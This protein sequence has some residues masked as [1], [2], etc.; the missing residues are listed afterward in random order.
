MKRAKPPRSGLVTRDSDIRR[1]LLADLYQIYGDKEQDLIVE[2]FGCN[3]ART[4]IAVINGSLHAFEIKS[5]SDTL[6]RLPSI[7]DRRVPGRVRVHD[8]SLR[9]SPLRPCAYRRSEMV[10]HTKGRAQRWHRC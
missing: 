7:T 1:V 5:D 10:G 8:P 9:S 2:E 4:D 6:D 3:S